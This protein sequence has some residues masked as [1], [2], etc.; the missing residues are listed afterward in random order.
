MNKAG[1]SLLNNPEFL[2]RDIMMHYSCAIRLHADRW[3]RT[4]DKPVEA[5]GTP[6]SMA[7]RA[8]VKT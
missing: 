2:G 7:D 3:M 4:A 8:C 1:S 6:R 5:M